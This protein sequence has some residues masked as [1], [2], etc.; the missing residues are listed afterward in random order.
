MEKE[1]IRAAFDLTRFGKEGTTSSGADYHEDRVSEKQG[2]W[3][4]EDRMHLNE[5]ICFNEPV[6]DEN[7]KCTELSYE[8]YHTREG[9]AHE[10]AYGYYEDRFG[11]SIEAQKQRHLASRHKK[12]AEACT[13][14]NHYDSDKTGYQYFELQVSEKGFLNYKDRDVFTPLA[15]EFCKSLEEEVKDKDGNL[16][17]RVHCVGLTIHYDE[18]N[19]HA[20]GKLAFEVLDKTGLWKPAQEEALKKLGY[21]SKLKETAAEKK[22]R[23]EAEANGQTVE[24]KEGKRCNAKI[25]WT[26]QKREEWCKLVE[27]HIPYVEV[28]R[29]AVRVQKKKKVDH[30][31]YAGQEALL[32]EMHDQKEAIRELKAEKEELLK[33]NASMKVKNEVLEEVAQK[34]QKASEEADRKL[35]DTCAEA[36]EINRTLVEV[37]AEIGVETDIPLPDLEQKETYNQNTTLDEVNRTMNLVTRLKASVDHFVNEMLKEYAPRF[38]KAYKA[39]TEA[40]EHYKDEAKNAKGMRQLKK[41]AE[42]YLDS[43]EKAGI[44]LEKGKEI[45]GKWA[46]GQ[47]VTTQEAEAFKGYTEELEALVPEEDWEM[48]L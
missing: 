19:A 32:E 42:N 21:K 37:L 22:D 12:E 33:E 23:E 34:H 8:K 4:K 26:E 1:V 16:I 15:L 46:T 47:K 2:K 11:A 44:P 38:L 20:H 17:A 10:H 9:M 3:I 39:L 24:Y 45:Y 35:L 31:L 36:E 5:V 43:Y 41:E 40:W 14:K 18:V 29:E 7:G 13:V 27:K 6:M 25:A 30:D 28:N 48:D